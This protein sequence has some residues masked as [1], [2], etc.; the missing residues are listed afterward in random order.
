MRSPEEKIQPP[1]HRLIEAY[2][3]FIM[4]ELNKKRP[5]DFG[6]KKIQK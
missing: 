5:E 3:M 6:L 4:P 2:K 1:K